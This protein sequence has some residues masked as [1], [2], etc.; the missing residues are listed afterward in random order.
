MKNVKKMRKMVNFTF[1]AVLTFSSV[2]LTEKFKVLRFFVG[3]PLSFDEK[4]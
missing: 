2:L 4:Y 1:F 3:V